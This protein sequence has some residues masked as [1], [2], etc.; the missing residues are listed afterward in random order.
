MQQPSNDELVGMLMTFG[1]M[2]ICSLMCTNCTITGIVACGLFED[3]DT[4]EL[5]RFGL[6]LMSGSGAMAVYRGNWIV[7]FD[8]LLPMYVAIK[9]TQKSL[10]P[11]CAVLC[12]P[13][14]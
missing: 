4:G 1:C 2:Y 14:M 10:I 8:I 9:H 12:C 7:C 11:P 6:V 13:D 5:K 3:W